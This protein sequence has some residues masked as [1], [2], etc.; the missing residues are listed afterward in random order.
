MPSGNQ[1][2]GDAFAHYLKSTDVC[3]VCAK[4]QGYAWQVLAGTSR[5][6]TLPRELRRWVC[7]LTCAETWEARHRPCGHPDCDGGTVVIVPP[8]ARSTNDTYQE[9]CPRCLG[10]GCEPAI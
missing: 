8:L 3:P 9:A 1:G 6:G 2:L 7:S 10:T 5:K 4:V